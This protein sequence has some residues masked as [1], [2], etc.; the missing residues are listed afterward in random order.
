MQSLQVSTLR[1]IDESCEPLEYFLTGRI[2]CVNAAVGLKTKIE[3]GESHTTGTFFARRINLVI[4][5]LSS[6]VERWKARVEELGGIVSEIDIRCAAFS[7]QLISFIRQSRIIQFSTDDNRLFAAADDLMK[8]I[9]HC[10]GKSG[11]PPNRIDVLLDTFLTILRHQDSAGHPSNL[12]VSSDRKYYQWLYT[13]ATS[14]SA[15]GHPQL[16]RSNDSVQDVEM[17]DSDDF[18]DSTRVRV[19]QSRSQSDGHNPMSL[20]SF[21]ASIC[22]RLLIKM[23]ETCSLEQCNQIDYSHIVEELSSMSASDIIAS[24]AVIM[25]LDIF[26]VLTEDI[27]IRILNILSEQVMKSY[28][29]QLNQASV[30]LILN[31]LIKT[32]AIWI[33]TTNRDLAGLVM[34]FY[35]YIVQGTLPQ[36]VLHKQSQILLS[37]L[38]VMIWEKD[39]NFA[40]EEDPPMPSV[41]TTL[42]N[43]L[44]QGSLA[45]RFNQAERIPTIFSYFTITNHEALFDDLEKNL[46]ADADWLEGISI[47]LA[48]FANLGSRWQSLL[49]RSVFGILDAAGQVQGCLTHAHQ[50]ITS[51]TTAHGFTD[52]CTLFRAFSSQ[53]LYSWMSTRNLH[54]IPFVIFGFETLP[55]LIQANSREITAQC[56]LCDKDEEFKLLEHH[57]KLS[58]LELVRDAYADTIAY[59]VAHDT[60]QPG[61]QAKTES[62]IRELFQNKNEYVTLAKLYLPMTIA[63]LIIATDIDSG[64]DRAFEKKRD[65]ADVSEAITAMTE[66]ANDT[67]PPMPISQPSFRA[68]HL[69]DSL[70]RIARRAGLEMKSLFRPQLFVAVVRKLL[71]LISPAL[72]STHTRAILFKIRLVCAFGQQALTAPYP[73]NTLIQ[74]MRPFLHDAQCAQEAISIIW[75]CYKNGFS[76]LSK[77]RSKV[78]A[79]ILTTITMLRLAAGQS[80]DPLTQESQRHSTLA[81][82]DKLRQWL[83]ELVLAFKEPW[84]ERQQQ[85]LLEMVRACNETNYPAI[86]DDKIPSGTYFTSLLVDCQSSTPILDEADRTSMIQL[87]MEH[88]QGSSYGDDQLHQRTI[89]VKFL[90]MLWTCVKTSKLTDGVCQWFGKLM[91]RSYSMSGP[92]FAEKILHS[93]VNNRLLIDSDF[94]SAVKFSRKIISDF[95]VDNIHSF[96]PIHVSL[97]EDAIRNMIHA[98]KITENINTIQEVLSTQIFEAFDINYETT[99]SAIAIDTRTLSKPYV[100][101]HHGLSSLIDLART[102]VLRVPNEASMSSLN[103]IEVIPESASKLLAPMLHLALVSK[104][105]DSFMLRSWLSETYRT[106]FAE[107]TTIPVTS[108]TVLLDCLLYLLCRPVDK[109]TTRLDRLEWLDIDFISAARAALSCKLPKHALFLLE[110]A[111]RFAAKVSKTRRS[112]TNNLVPIEIPNELMLAIFEMIEDPD[113]YY[114]V[115]RLPTLDSIVQRME[116]QQD[117]LA[118]LMLHSACLDSTTRLDETNSGSHEITSAIALGSLNLNSLTQNLLRQQSGREDFRLSDM[119][120]KVSQRLYQ[121]DVQVPA[122]TSSGE[123][124]VFK[125]LQHL[126]HNSTI[127]SSQLFVTE[128]LG[129]ATKI[130]QNLK[131]T[132]TKAV[133]FFHAMAIASDIQAILQCNSG[134]SVFGLQSELDALDSGWGNA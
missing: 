41:R 103:C 134:T 62:K 120:M 19:S 74:A 124:L 27:A 21:N 32:F 37:E 101:L 116:R 118:A 76:A 33:H 42:F 72:G 75:F 5:Q 12:F 65:L 26:H 10:L 100:S 69:L 47:R 80:F 40:Q 20:I 11:T 81:H 77:T 119:S 106:A 96:N 14:S 84:N 114:S 68:R 18:D 111:P 91:G 6:V 48:V 121:W 86:L 110:Q 125:M 49:R 98:F 87:L 8:A 57:M 55:D 131:D 104:A 97:A 28:I 54:D 115:D 13:L 59:A 29:E 107:S 122:L 105:N 7:L 66:F 129:E 46:P 4:R 64:L 31:F 85:R 9:C 16:A 36:R 15:F 132:S 99:K 94:Y 35:E 102:I 79:S 128:T 44:G 67:R 71:D 83:V 70:D 50:A 56:F 82:L 90:P 123:G 63:K 51:I 52:E 73:V 127:E 117:P 22:N 2:H 113:I 25:E 130:L 23:F 109:E 24:R 38:L 93:G 1:L 88:S 3:P 108:L 39:E 133:S 89:A 58:K 45:L 78:V 30:E 61:G 43:L 112:S 126:Q 60:S 92:S 34:D 95:L 53:L 17:G